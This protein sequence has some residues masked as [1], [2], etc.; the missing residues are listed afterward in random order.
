MT[1]GSLAASNWILLGLLIRREN[2]PFLE[3]QVA[4][5]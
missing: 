4:A 5:I 3:P 1:D 2:H